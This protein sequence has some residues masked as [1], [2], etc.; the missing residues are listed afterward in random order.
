MMNQL[1]EVLCD[2]K[3]KVR[4]DLMFCSV[5]CIVVAIATS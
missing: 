2:R 5:D 1:E 4:F 3:G